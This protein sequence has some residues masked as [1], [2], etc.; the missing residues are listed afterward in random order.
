VEF[1]V[2]ATDA[3]REIKLIV[4]PWGYEMTLPEGGLILRVDGEGAEP[5][6][7]DWHSDAVVVWPPRYTTLKVF[8]RKGEELID[9]D[10]QDIPEVPVRP[11]LW[12]Q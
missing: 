8:T 3:D 10:T 5:M 7:I 6:A 9:F 4:E 2:D 11:R 12:T 1:F